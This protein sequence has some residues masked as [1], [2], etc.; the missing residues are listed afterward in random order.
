MSCNHELGLKHVIS[1]LYQV[2]ICYQFF[3]LLIFRHNPI[4]PCVL[5]FALNHE[6]YISLRHD[7]NLTSTSSSIAWQCHLSIVWI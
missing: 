2:V 3:T 4:R 7:L 6:I 5:V 1:K